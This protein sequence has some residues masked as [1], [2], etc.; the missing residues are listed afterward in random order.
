VRGSAAD[1]QVAP[2]Y[3]DYQVLFHYP[4]AKGHELK[5][6]AF[7]SEDE[8]VFLRDQPA[9][10]G[11]ADLRGDF[12]NNTLFHRLYAGYTYK[13]GLD[14]ENRLSASG[15]IDRFLLK[16]YDRFDFIRDVALVS[17]R[18][19]SRFRFSPNALLALGL[20]AQLGRDR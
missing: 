5:V 4:L 7:G 13:P 20:D 8:L 16:V 19:E 12:R 1:L 6:M 14:F 18:N 11:A 9:G 17:L 3:Y 10:S 15:G 2:R